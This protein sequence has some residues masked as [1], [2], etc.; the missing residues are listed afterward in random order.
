M[1]TTDTKPLGRPP[2]GK[3]HLRRPRSI[4]G[5]LIEFQPD[6]VEIEKRSVPGGARWTLYT[7]VALI[8]ATI[9]WACW[10]QVDKIVVAQGKLVA[11]EPPVVIQ[12]LSA[13]PIREIL[14]RFGDTVYPN[15]VLATFDRTFSEADVAI[16]RAK[17][18]SLTASLARLTAERD[19]LEFK[20]G[21]T[22]ISDD[23][24]SQL[25]AF[26]DRKLEHAAKL[27]SFVAEH[28][29]LDAQQ[30]ANEEKI[31]TVLAELDV[32]KKLY[33]K[34][35]NLREKNV[36]SE[37]ELWSAVVELRRTEQ[38][39]A[40]ANSQK[41]QLQQDLELNA[42]RREEYV[43]HRNAEISQEYAKVQT[44][45]SQANEE[46]NKATRMNEYVDLRVPADLPHPAYFVMEV[47]ERS[48]G[49]VPQSSESLFKLVPLEVGVQGLVAEFDIEA[50]DI[51]QIRIDDTARIKLEAFPYQKHGTLEGKVGTISEGTFAHGE[52]PTSKI[53][54]K[55]RAS[56]GSAD[57]LKNMPEPYR[58]L[59]GSTV[60]VEIVV[61]KRRVIE[62]FLYPLIRTMDSATREP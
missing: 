22:Q 6:A 32:R 15:D 18:D 17:V 31:I 20:L 39:L 7:V 45:L 55:A 4:P 1:A 33:E 58:L 36:I 49:S 41:V 48:A 47:A 19:G 12:P 56:L 16:Y 28:G 11:T 24:R 44:E 52:G 62:Y 21:P 53:M 34:Q 9:A 26:S 60:T 23:W 43:A 57:R 38:S 42:K 50:R 46:L 54:Y 10:A 27:A 61:G 35:L 59:P 8:A 40:E 30:S 5:N 51:G 14:V 29:K 25:R 3:V 13:A 37:V 2:T